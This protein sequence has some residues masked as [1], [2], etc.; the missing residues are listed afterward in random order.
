MNAK[1]LLAALLTAA[2]CL[3]L[4]ACARREEEQARDSLSLWY[5]AGSPLAN[6]LERLAEAY[7]GSLSGDLPE[8]SLRAF[9]DEEALAAAFELT[10][11]DLLLCSHT[12]AFDLYGRGALRPVSGGPAYSEALTQYSSC[13]GESYFPV[14]FPALL[15]YARQD[16]LKDGL[17]ENL[18]ALLTLAGNY[19]REN[20]VPFL[21]ADSFSA[22]LYDMMLCLGS[23]LH[24]LRAR[25]ISNKKYVTAYNMLA[26]AAYTGGLAAADYSA[27]ALVQSGYLPCAAV[28]SADLRGAE[29]EGYLIAPLPR[30]E[31]RVYLAWAEGFAVT[32]PEGRSL[33]RVSSFLSWLMEDGRMASLALDGNLV[34][35][36]SAEAE[37]SG[38]LSAALLELARSYEPHLPAPGCDW[39]QN[40]E[41]LEETL[42]RAVKLLN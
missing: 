20:R 31:G 25:D 41:A 2:F 13:V 37:A 39:L 40:R 14:G 21:T 23:E 10:R 28:F 30:L 27:A 26:E 11:P 42:R 35:A 6:P 5:I 19:G 29:T 17:P 18:E 9:A 4:A 7:N 22:L 8:L 12:R 36:L 1:R 15:L 16:A 33:R 24:G 3:S 38:P 32:A 34:P